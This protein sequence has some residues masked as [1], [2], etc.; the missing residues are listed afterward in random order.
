MLPCTREGEGEWEG[1]KGALAQ[2][3]HQKVVDQG[4]GWDKGK[5]NVLFPQINSG[6]PCPLGA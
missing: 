6:C 2:L 4:L 1:G 5:G 3:L